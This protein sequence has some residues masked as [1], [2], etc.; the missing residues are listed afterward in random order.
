MPTRE[1]TRVRASSWI[2]ALAQR[3][4]R[5]WTSWSRRR[6]EKRLAK[7]E[8][9]LSL[10]LLEVD[11]Q[12][13]LIKELEQKDLQ[14]EHRQAEMTAALLWRENPQ[15]VVESL[16]QPEMEANPHLRALLGPVMSTPPPSSPSGEKS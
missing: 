10:L 16:P 3:S 9:R 8:R 4:R 13:L 2:L 6:V 12:N 15:Q 14:L 5:S 11:H 1:R 7:A